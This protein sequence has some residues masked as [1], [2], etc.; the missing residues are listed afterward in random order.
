MHNHYHPH[1][2]Q[3][4]HPLQPPPP[5]PPSFAGAGQMLYV[6][7]P[8]PPNPGFQYQQHSPP[9]A[10]P[11][12]GPPSYVLQQAPS[13][14]AGFQYYQ[15]PAP[16]V[17]APNMSYYSVQHDQMSAPA[18]LP[19][20]VA[21]LMQPQLA[22]P[23]SQHGVMQNTVTYPHP[24]AQLWAPHLSIHPVR[25]PYP[26][27]G[28]AVTAARYAPP[29]N[30]NAALSTA[31]V[32]LPSK[33]T[34]AHIGTALDNEI[35]IANHKLVDY[36]T[37]F[38]SMHR[39]KALLHI[40]A[41]QRNI[42]DF[43]AT[44]AEIFCHLRHQ[45]VSPLLRVLIHE[46]TSSGEVLPRALVADLTQFRGILWMSCLESALFPWLSESASDTVPVSPD[47]AAASRLIQSLANIA[48]SVAATQRGCITLM[49]AASAV[50]HMPSLIS[51][52]VEMCT[53]LAP[54]TLR[55]EHGAFVLCHLLC[56]LDDA[57]FSPAPSSAECDSARQVHG[58]LSQQRDDEVRANHIFDIS[59]W[60]QDLRQTD[61][62]P[63]RAECHP[64]VW[65]AF[66]DAVL[67]ALHRQLDVVVR[68]RQQC[69]VL[70]HT[71]RRVPI[72]QLA[73]GRELLGA[74]GSPSQ[75]ITWPPKAPPARSTAETDAVEPN[76]APAVAVTPLDALCRSTAGRCALVALLNVLIGSPLLRTASDLSGHPH[77]QTFLASLRHLCVRGVPRVDRALETTLKMRP[78]MEFAGAL[79]A[80][81]GALWQFVDSLDS[82]P[83]A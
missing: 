5:L 23:V 38:D 66:V 10:P 17:T 18:Q 31:G 83:A 7:L 55:D 64:N 75:I 16:F 57:S 73:R 81:L 14:P 44:D 24:P 39:E 6:A 8:Q 33:P 45:A 11:Q 26:A 65:A 50:H 77:V 36:A 79:E 68:G 82:Q 69:F 4:Q 60:A 46:F 62:R 42:T 43:R 9:N 12:H 21:F 49:R 61:D 56:G 58:F 27:Q 52:V 78:G 76:G 54:Q 13:T 29:Q 80:R 22:V 51:L 25:S 59:R 41:L 15:V 1:Q 35:R 20:Q 70:W 74:L 2:H 72:L 37:S 63:L 3:H 34:R 71:F 30:V 53:A 19:E 48:S 67:V 40:E 32:G 47:T 28:R